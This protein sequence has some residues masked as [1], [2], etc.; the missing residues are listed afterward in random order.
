[1]LATGRVRVNGATAHRA[2]TVLAAG[3]VVEVA[4]RSR[5]AALP[6]GLD[7][8]YEDEDL[9][10]VD[11]PAG[12]LTI[13]TERERQRTV[14]RHLTARARA[15]RP[16]GRVFVVHR[17]DRLASGLLVFEIGRAHV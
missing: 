4:A 10:V 14:Y 13:A 7:L 1:M 15:R 6:G 16:P 2:D 8:V 11:K 17:L 3:D 9:L 12:L 5:G